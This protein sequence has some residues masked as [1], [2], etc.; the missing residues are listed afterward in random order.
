MAFEVIDQWGSTAEER[1][2]RYP[3][4]ELLSGPGQ[5]LF[6]AVSIDASPSVVFR[7]LCQLKLAPYSY[8]LIDNGARRSPRHLVPGADR[9]VAGEEIMIFKLA[10][11]ARDEHLTLELR[12]HRVFGDLAMTY[13][14][15]PEANHTTRLVVELLVVPPPGMLGRLLRAVLPLGDLVMM[16]RQLL[17]LKALAEATD[18]SALGESTPPGRPTATRRSS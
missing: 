9:L 2:R 15:V 6:R 18:P 13:A 5:V 8:D 1:R 12:G 3:C 10:S 11:F 16:R 4:D 7:W 17:N 14:V